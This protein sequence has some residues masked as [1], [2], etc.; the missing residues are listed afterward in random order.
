MNNEKII[1]KI[2]GL[3]ALGDAAKNCEEKEAQAALLKAHELMAKYNISVEI[4]E[5]EKI[6][7]VH[8]ECE[9]KWNMGFR[10]P[11]AR[12]IADNFRC[13][14]YLRGSGGSIVFFGHSTD[15]RIAREVFEFAYSFA[16][17][18]GNRCYNKN[19]QMGRE[20]RGVFNS[21]VKGFLKGLKEKM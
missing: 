15:A 2:K 11:L 19:Y 4:T 1:E 5:E 18:E 21:Y 13:Q 12:I 20:T 9:S 7:Y 10:K 17:K 6:S 3:L 14:H 16:M 8:E